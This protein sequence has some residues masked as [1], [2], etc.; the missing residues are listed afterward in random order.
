MV[1]LLRDKC[2]TAPCELG[3]QVPQCPG[4]IRVQLRDH[5]PAHLH[6]HVSSV[7]QHLLCSIS[8]LD[9]VARDAFP[10]SPTL[11]TDP[12]LP[13]HPSHLGQLPGSR[14]AANGDRKSTRLNSS[15]VASSYA[16]FCLK[17]KN[18]T[19]SRR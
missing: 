13:Q 4:H 11:E 6:V 16:V 17:K 7:G 3:H 12:R 8:V 10:H 2:V 18:V 5:G 14:H 19:S 15:H 1:V 9:E